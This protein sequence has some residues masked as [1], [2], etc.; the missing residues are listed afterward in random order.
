MVCGELGKDQASPA[1]R[2][3]QRPGAR[4][5]DFEGI[6]EFLN[7]IIFFFIEIFFWILVKPFLNFYSKIFP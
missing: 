5:G 1:L 6:G 4:G 7:I 3:A 2:Q